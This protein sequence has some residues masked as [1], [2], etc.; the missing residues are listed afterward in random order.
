[1]AIVHSY[2]KLPEGNPWFTHHLRPQK[3]S[4]KQRLQVA[5]VRQLWSK[6]P[7]ERTWT[8][9]SLSIHLFSWD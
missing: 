3:T 1:M 8:T 5:S 9:E 6:E 4:E 2:V 7:K